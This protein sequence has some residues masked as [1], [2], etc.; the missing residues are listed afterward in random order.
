MSMCPHCN[1]PL[2]P[3]PQSQSG[4]PG[5][6]AYMVSCTHCEAILRVEITTLKEPDQE[7]IQRGRKE[8]IA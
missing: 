4:I 1:Y 6:V 2:I 3:R 8:K 7:R 5:T